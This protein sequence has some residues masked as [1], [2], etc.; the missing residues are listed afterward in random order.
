MQNC[1]NNIIMSPSSLNAHTL[2]NIVPMISPSEVNKYSTFILLTHTRPLGLRG[3][4][5]CPKQQ[6]QKGFLHSSVQLSISDAKAETL[7]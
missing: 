5:D 3:G 1:D 6:T 4:A 7:Q 2:N